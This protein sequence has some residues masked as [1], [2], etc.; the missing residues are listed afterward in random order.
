MCH[1]TKAVS[2]EKSWKTQIS[3]SEVKKSWICASLVWTQLPLLIP[4]NFPSSSKCFWLVWFDRKAW[5]EA[6]RR[7]PAPFQKFVWI[8]ISSGE[9][10]LGDAPRVCVKERSEMF[11]CL[12]L[13]MYLLLSECEREVWWTAKTC[14]RPSSH[15]EEPETRGS[16]WV[17]RKRHAHLTHFWAQTHLIHMSYFSCVHVFDFHVIAF[18][19][20]AKKGLCCSNK[21][22]HKTNAC[23]P[24]SYLNQWHQ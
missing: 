19:W 5:A 2:A 21:Y 1:V 14:L 24:E 3:I 20:A 11:K 15:Q 9:G 18:V 12:F 10:S 22:I 13:R 17:Y 4:F 16:L 23:S 6:D 7:R 8:R